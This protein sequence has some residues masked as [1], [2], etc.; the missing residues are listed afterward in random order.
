[1]NMTVLGSWQ[2]A[3]LILVYGIVEYR[4][5]ERN[6]RRALRGAAS[7]D[8]EPAAPGDV[9]L[10]NLV[11]IGVVAL[12]LAFTIFWFLQQDMHIPGWLDISPETIAGSLIPILL[13]VLLMF[14]R[15]LFSHSGKERRR[16]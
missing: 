5:R 12:I 3:L 11:L 9:S 1:M 8:A 15:D 10:L 7:S 2:V 14:A 6:H 16:Q 4:R 13:V